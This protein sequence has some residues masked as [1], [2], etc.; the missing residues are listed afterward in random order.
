MNSEFAPI[1]V[2]VYTRLDHLSRCL[3]SLRQNYGCELTDLYIVSDAA[4]SASDEPAVTSVRNYITTISGFR[5]TILIKR[6]NNLGSFISIT[7]AI[8]EVLK[9]HGR[10]IFLEDDNVVSENFLKFMNDS[11]LFYNNDSSIF[12]IC[13]YNFP[14]N[15]PKEYPHGIYKWQGF[16]AWGVG[17]WYDRWLEIDWSSEAIHL[18]LADTYLVTALNRISEHVLPCL[19]THLKKNHLVADAAISIHLVKKNKYTVFPVISKVRNLGHDGTG[20]HGGITDKYSNQEIDSNG[21][22]TLIENIQPDKRINRILS[23]HFSLPL[24][25]KLKHLIPEPIRYIV[26]KLY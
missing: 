9:E 4:F 3:D 25:A 17:L 6:E 5:N 22:F 1:L 24:K 19:T 13:G 21:P 12:S 26:K 8:T 7:T 10:V 20:E 2:S 23:R 15:I 16:S 18:F 11:L 14:V